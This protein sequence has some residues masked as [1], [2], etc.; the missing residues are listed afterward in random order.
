MNKLVSIIIPFYN[1][2]KYISECIVSVQSQTYN[3]WELILVNDGSIDR[4][5][6]IC[7]RFAS[8]DKRIKI[9]DKKNTGV[10]DS[11]NVALDIAKG[12]YVIFLD[13]D[14]Y[15][16]DNFIL[17]KM[18]SNADKYKL[19]IVR[20]EY[21]E[22]DEKGCS[23]EISYRKNKLKKEVP[24]IMDSLSFLQDIIAGEYFLW[25][26][27]IRYEKIQNIRFSIQKHYLEDAEFF[28][29]IM[30]QNMKCM[31]FPDVFYT[32]RKHSD[33]VTMKITPQLWGDILDFVRLCFN[34]SDKAF[35]CR[36]K[37]FLLKEGFNFFFSNMHLISRYPLSLKEK[38]LAL[39][40]MGIDELY[41]DIKRRLHETGVNEKY[42]E[43]YLTYKQLLVYY[44]YKY[45][46]KYY[47]KKIVPLQVWR[48]VK[49]YCYH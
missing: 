28:L 11:R 21:K 13:S 36:M 26:C 15:W 22:V 18:V 10:S 3:F 2:E 42:S 46:L 9:I 45:L 7:S 34:L 23:L 38:I 8:E 17:E 44:K 27:L 49:L 48:Q 6:H 4:S 39:K 20:A 47:I 30:Q 24:F 43:W 12:E 19:D 41:K 16:C 31:Y 33:S 35:D 1:V 29:C 40:K 32:Y 5:L 14:D 25:L 37:S